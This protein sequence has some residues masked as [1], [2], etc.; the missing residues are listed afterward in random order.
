MLIK[1]VKSQNKFSK[2]NERGVS[3]VIAVTLIVALVIV[4]AAVIAAIIFGSAIFVHKSAFVPVNATVD[5]K[6][7][8]GNVVNVFN[9]GGDVTFHN[10]SASKNLTPKVRFEIDTPSGGWW[11]VA[12]NPDPTRFNSTRWAAGDSVYIYKG[13]DGNYWMVDNPSKIIDSEIATIDYPIGVRVIDATQE[14]LIARIN[15]GGVGSAGGSGTGGLT[16]GNLNPNTAPAG[17]PDTTM[18]ITGTGF[19]PGSTVS[20]GGIILTPTSITSTSIAVTIPQTYLTNPGI[21][22]VSVTNPGGGSSGQLPFTITSS[23]GPTITNLNPNSATQNGPTF[24]MVVTGTNFV[25]GAKVY[26]GTTPL[27]TTFGS[28]TSLTATVPASLL[29]TSGSFDITVTNPDNGTSG[30]ATFTVSPLPTITSLNPSSTTQNGAGFSMTVTGTNYVNGAVVYWGNTP[31]TT[32]F[33]SSTLLTATV[34]STLL[35]TVGSL[36]IT[37]KNPDNGTS[38]PAT[39]TVN[40]LPTITSLNPS[41]STQ[42]GAGFSMTVT[43]TNYVNGAVVYWGTTPLTTTF[44]SSTSLTATVPSTLLTTVGSLDITVKNPD[45]GTSGPAT[46][47]VSAQSVPTITSLNPSSATQNGAGFSMT[48]TGT[49]YVN[50]AVVYWGNTPLTTTFGSSTSLTATV[51]STLLTTVGSLDITVKNPD[52]GTSGP[53]TFT[54]NAP[55]PTITSLNPSSSTQNG[56]GFSMTVTG[57]NYVNG[58][59]VYWGNTPLTT[60]Y[61]SSTSLTA[62]VPSSLLT[63]AGSFSITVKNPSGTTSGA[64][65]FTVNALPTI[66][67]LNPSSAIQNGAGFSMTVTGTNYVNG[68]VVYWGNTPLTTTFGSSTSLTATVPSSL[69][70]T[71]GSFSITVK[72]PSGATSGAAT[73]IV[74]TPI[75]TITTIS[76]NSATAGSSA[77]TMTVTGTNYISGS[78]VYWGTTA[79]TTTY[80]SGTQLTATIPSTL[81]TS[82]GTGTI[83]VHNPGG[84]TSNSATFIITSPPAPDSCSESATGRIWG[85]VYNDLNSN[86]KWDAGEPIIASRT[87]DIV[88]TVHKVDTTYH[89]TT[90]GYGKYESDCFH[91]GETDYSVSIS[92]P[93]GWTVTT[94]NNPTSDHLSN[95]PNNPEIDFG[96]HNS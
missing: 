66:T 76:P 24:D 35:T 87:V 6:F 27:T 48:V 18:V 28:S 1:K 44:G 8:G 69:L 7:H 61:G 79:L 16:I 64:A 26:W 70:T 58:A 49:N 75:P 83:T 63:T 15:V 14:I 3:T 53:A 95:S 38:V 25:D 55:D 93:S 62:T 23:T 17:S 9:R 46:F 5:P 29:S 77:V 74:N 10:I 96:L 56:A 90:D 11:K 82:A 42:N 60:T 68:A 43:G 41:S 4:L 31:L 21:V 80:N 30:P 33:G 92:P 39:F 32:T 12:P 94:G 52:N 65:T 40:P 84:S 85:V 45:N 81:L 20:F 71:A 47:T 51:P 59:V 57:T 36:D 91:H 13:T 22:Q 89:Y 2:D 86:G 54:V 37:V 78:T 73:F 34:P 19:V 88:I 72:N 50:G 67:S